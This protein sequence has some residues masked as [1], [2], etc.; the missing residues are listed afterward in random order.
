MKPP[1]SAARGFVFFLAYSA[2]MQ[3][4]RHISA[5]EMGLDAPDDHRRS[6]SADFRKTLAKTLELLIERTRDGLSFAEIKHQLALP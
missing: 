4:L 5:Q 3:Q 2:L 1:S 6:L